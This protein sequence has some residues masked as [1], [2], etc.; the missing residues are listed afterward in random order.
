MAPY[1]QNRKSKKG[2]SIT[3]GGILRK[4]IVRMLNNILRNAMHKTVLFFYKY[5][6][7]YVF[8]GGKM[9]T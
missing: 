8:I 4:Q 7:M 9:E 3:T 1:L 2:D 6:E 5:K